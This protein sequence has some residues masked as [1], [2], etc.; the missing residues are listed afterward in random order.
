VGRE[1]EV[2]LIAYSIWEEEGCQSGQECEHWYRAEEIWE[3]KQ[4]AQAYTKNS[5]ITAKPAVK[6]SE[7]AVASKKKSPRR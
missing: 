5:P 1:D 6:K 2:R 3:G 7:K 4:K